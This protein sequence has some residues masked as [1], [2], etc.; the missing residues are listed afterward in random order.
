M[1]FEEVHVDTCK[2]IINCIDDGKIIIKGT[3][4]DNV[5]QGKIL[6][7]A[8]CPHDSRTSWSGSGLPFASPIQA[9]ENTPNRHVVELGFNNKFETILSIPNSYYVGLG[10][11][12]IPPTVFI[13]YSNG[14]KYNLIQI[15]ISNG[16][17]YRSLTYPI[18]T[19][20]KS[21]YGPDFYENDNL[22]VRSQEQILKDSAFPVKDCNMHYNIPENFW[23]SKPPR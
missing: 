11:V 10:T 8:A 13:R 6:I 12:L 18:S 22:T 4:E 15:K 3:I 7:L 16:I 21:R 1:E 2:C 9:F 5:V 20:Y 19:E 14:D 17:P 23:G